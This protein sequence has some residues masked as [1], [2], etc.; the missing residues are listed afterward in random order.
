MK[1]IIVLVTLLFS[2]FIVSALSNS[3]N[4]NTSNLSFSSNSKKNNIA[5]SFNERYK[6]NY[7]IEEDNSELKEEIKN[8]SK[9]TTYLLFGDFNNNNETSE[10]FYNRKMEF[11]SSGG[12]VQIQVC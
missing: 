12:T 6:L 9:K 4:L 8:L 10:H 7:S 3:F 11:Y 1:K 5:S 2:T